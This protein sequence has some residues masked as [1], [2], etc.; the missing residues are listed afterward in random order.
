MDLVAGQIFDLIWTL[1]DLELTRSYSIAT[2]AARFSS[3]AMAP[4]WLA[5][6]L[7]LLA[8]GARAAMR[9]LD[10]LLE[11][12]ERELCSNLGDGALRRRSALTRRLPRRRFGR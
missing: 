6:F 3:A 10:Q 7:H 1:R 5:A 12:A 4:G 9:K 2:L 11:V 8:E